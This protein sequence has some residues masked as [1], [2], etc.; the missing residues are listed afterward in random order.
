[1]GNIEVSFVLGILNSE[2]TLRECLD[3][4]FLQD[5]PKNKYEVIIID[6][7]S[8]DNT[9]K[10]IEEYQ[11]KH[12]NIRVLHNPK[13][14]SEGK[15]MSKDMGIESAK[16]TYVALIDGDNILLGKNWLCEMLVP[17][18]EDSSIM[19]S[20]SLLNYQRGDTNFLKYVNAIGVEDPFAVPNSL[21][22]Q[23]V[24]YPEKFKLR[25]AYYIHTLQAN[26]VLFGGA[27][28]CIFRKEVFNKIGGYTRDVDVFACMA[29]YSMNVAVPLNPRVYHK[30][31]S[32]LMNFM[33]KK[34]IYFYR[35]ITYDYGWKKFR[36]IK[37]GFRGKAEFLLQIAYN[38]SI[39]G[40][41]MLSF[42]E[43]ART[44]K[45]FWLI[46]PFYLYFIT[47]EYALISLWK[48]GNF[49]NYSFK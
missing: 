18:N 46:H 43:I 15:G 35:F 17:L 38:L 23:V 28:G 44:R 40:P 10:I 34:G 9:L 39:L 22:A 19:A 25:D 12:S 14:L 45:L 4:I 47:L 8:T 26:H 41:L 20:Q 31:T 32:N 48:F 21:V 5:Y 2:R 37:K 1:M 33:K 3:G 11:F 36:W 13:K 16:G 27:N 42:K 29:D 6:G 7:G 30:T 24:L 49:R